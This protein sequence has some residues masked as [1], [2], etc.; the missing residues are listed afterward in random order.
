MLMQLSY[1]EVRGD[2]THM[3]QK[4]QPWGFVLPKLGYFQ[5]S[6]F[7]LDKLTQE[8]ALRHRLETSEVLVP[9]RTAYTNVNCRIKQIPLDSA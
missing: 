7:S 3:W 6:A 8:V 5:V 4:W 1:A 9:I 2:F